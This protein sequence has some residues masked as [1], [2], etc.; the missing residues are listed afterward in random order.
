MIKAIVFDLGGV[1]VK[2]NPK[3]PFPFI[4]T[5]EKWDLGLQGKIKEDI[6]WSDFANKHDSSSKELQTIKRQLWKNKIPD[7]EVCQLLP[8]LHKNY[9]L[10]VV[11]NT[12][13]STFHYRMEKYHLGE[14][15]DVQICSAEVGVRKPDPKIFQM[16]L[17]KLGTLPQETVVIDDNAE[18][19]KTTHSL[20]I[21]P[22]LYKDAGQLKQDLKKLSVLF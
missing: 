12:L 11:S 14:Y 3:I 1:L 17:Q 20:G 13:P 9:K 2:N 10:A 15:F 19:I 5:K 6:L 4:T 22:I 8:H 16:A 21:H 7:T 18:N